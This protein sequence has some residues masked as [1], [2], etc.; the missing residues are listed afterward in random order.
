[1]CLASRRRQQQRHASAAVA[2]QRNTEHR[3]ST[4]A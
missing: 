4:T 2:P 3:D 1:M